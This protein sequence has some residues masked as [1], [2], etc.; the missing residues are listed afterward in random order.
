M[1]VQLE[2]RPVALASAPPTT[3]FDLDAVDSALDRGDLES[4]R[5]LLGVTPEAWRLMLARL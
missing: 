2:A 3:D 4:V 5:C 1:T